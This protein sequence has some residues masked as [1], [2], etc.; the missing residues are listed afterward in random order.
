MTGAECICCRPVDYNPIDKD[1]AMNVSPMSDANV[2]NN[3]D[4]RPIY[5][6]PPISQYDNTKGKN[7]TSFTSWE[8][9]NDNGGRY[10]SY[11][12][13]SNSNP[14]VIQRS[15]S[16]T[17][18]SFTSNLKDRSYDSLEQ[19]YLS[20][21]D[22]D[23][24]DSKYFNQS[25]VLGEEIF[26]SKSADLANIIYSPFQGCSSAKTNGSCCGSNNS[27]TMSICRCGSGCKCTGCDTNAK[28]VDIGN[29]YNNIS[30]QQNQSSSSCCSSSHEITQPEHTVIRDED[31]VLLCGCGCQKLNTD[32]SDCLESLCEGT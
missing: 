16:Y 19:S 6:L 29:T 1:L 7:T 9:C 21:Y 24:K 15:D 26:R 2:N 18:N 30:F 10:S 12:G 13:Q 22:K 5:T 4:Q 28:R 11:S 31:G 14:S 27:P 32:C 3:S 23:N 25:E 17:S 20:S 8:I